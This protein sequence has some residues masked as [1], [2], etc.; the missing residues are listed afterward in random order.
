MPTGIVKRVPN[1][2]KYGFVLVGEGPGAE[3]VFFHRTDVADDGFEKLQDGQRVTFEVIPDTRHPRK[4]RA[5]KVQPVG[6]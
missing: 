2:D 3:E 6:E 4:R 5:V 1:V